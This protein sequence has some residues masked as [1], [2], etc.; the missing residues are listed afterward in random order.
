MKAEA[1]AKWTSDR[2]LWALVASNVML[3]VFAFFQQWSIHTIMWV[4]WSQSVIIGVFN[5][6]KIMQTKGVE[7]KHQMLPFAP[8][9]KY[10]IAAFFAVHYGG[11][12]FGY[13]IFLLASTFA[14]VPIYSSIPVSW[15]SV[16]AFSGLFLVNHYY[17]YNK[18]KKKDLVKKRTPTVQ[19]MIPY[20][21]IIPMHIT[22]IVG[23]LL[24]EKVIILFLVLKTIADAV[25]HVREHR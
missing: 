14:G 2:S 8:H 12:H 25:M 18:N 16:L 1:K 21:R 5:V 4:Y 6:F 15:L 11:F 19:M 22:I 7:P 20:A 13:M 17:S 10:P 3:I 24:Q 9:L 23:A